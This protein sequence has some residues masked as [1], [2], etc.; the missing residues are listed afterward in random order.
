MRWIL[1]PLSFLLAS[2]SSAEQYE[3]L[4]SHK[5]LKETTI[6]EVGDVEKLEPP[7]NVRWTSDVLK[8]AEQCVQLT[9]IYPGNWS[10]GKKAG[11]LLVDKFLI[12]KIALIE[13]GIGSIKVT[14]APVEIVDCQSVLSDKSPSMDKILSDM[15]KRQDMYRR[16]QEAAQKELER[17]KQQQ[18]QLNQSR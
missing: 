9:G 18:Q 4:D 11:V 6:I 2:L 7:P 15:K 12:Y 3:F 16:R 14:T 10:Y 5:E 1:I 17:L 8:I 13:S